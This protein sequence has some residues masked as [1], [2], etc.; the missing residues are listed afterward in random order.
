L[1]DGE[2][3]P[4]KLLALTFDDGPSAYTNQVLDILK[5]HN[6]HATFFVMGQEVER[7]PEIVKRMSEEGHELGNHTYNFVAQKNIFFSG[8]DLNDI[9]RNQ[10]I[11]EKYSGQRP[12]LYR[13]P[14]G[15]AGRFLFGAIKKEKLQ[16]VNGVF[17]M[18]HPKLNAQEQ[19]DIAV[20]TI[21]PGAIIILH[22]GDDHSPDSERPKATVELL[23]DLLAEIKAKGFQVL[24]VSELL[25]K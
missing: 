2:G 9:K 14:G 12:T 21:K 10:N 13:S 8:I 5:E 11:I 4:E 17:P 18:P 22:D 24:T 15:Q 25:S 3:N 16:V 6:A 20:K 23:P 1:K 7:Y 19:F